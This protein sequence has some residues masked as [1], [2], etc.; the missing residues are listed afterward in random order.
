MHITLVKKILADGSPCSKCADIIERLES[1]GNMR[2]IDRVIVADL[3][4]P[5]SEGVQLAQQHQVERAPFF[6][7]Q[8]DDGQTVIYTVYLK[9]VKEILEPRLG[10]APA[11]PAV[12]DTDELKDIMESNPDLDFL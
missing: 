12:V 5:A 10:Q 1:S 2:F 4:D 6:I 9:L 3:R 8:Q 11:A 7:V